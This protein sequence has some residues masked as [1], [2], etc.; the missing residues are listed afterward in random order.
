[1]LRVR[2]HVVQFETRGTGQILDGH[3]GPE[4]AGFTSAVRGRTA[5]V[6]KYQIINAIVG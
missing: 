1:M 4:Q 6:W 5:G 2:G 3:A